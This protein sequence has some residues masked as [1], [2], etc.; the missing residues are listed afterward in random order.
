MSSNPGALT[1]V[2]GT[3]FFVADDGTSELELWKSDGTAASIMRVADI[4]PGPPLAAKREQL[5][6]GVALIELAL[7][8]QLGLLEFHSGVDEIFDV[9]LLPG[10][11]APFVA[12][13]YPD[14]DGQQTVWLAPSAGEV[15]SLSAIPG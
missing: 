9:Q 7:G 5:K 10:A 8:R 6:C 1:T 3:L 12:G 14:I 13:P 2:D 11:H 4:A 15:P